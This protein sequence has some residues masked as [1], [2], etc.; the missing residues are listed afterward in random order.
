MEIIQQKLIWF[1]GG[2]AALILLYKLQLGRVGLRKSTLTRLK[3]GVI[4]LMFGSL[5]GVSLRT[6][7]PGSA[8]AS[9]TVAFSIETILGYTVGWG[10]VIWGLVSWGRS[11]FDLRGKPLTTAGSRVISDIITKAMLR[12]DDGKLLFNSFFKELSFILNSQA[13][14][15][16]KI[17]DD[18]RLQ[19]VFHQGLTE[20]SARLLEFPRGDRNVF[21]ITAKSRQAVISDENH[22]LHEFSFPE[23][24]RGQISASISIPVTYNGQLL[25]VM[26][27]YRNKN[28]HFNEDDM[29]VLEIA[30]SGLGA[31]LHK[32]KSDKEHIQEVRYKELLTIA[33]KSLDTGQPMLSALIKSAKTVYNYLPFKWI[34]LYVI[35]NGTPRAYEFNLPTGGTVKIIEGWFPKYAFPHLFNRDPNTGLK[36]SSATGKIP[37]A[38]TYIFPVGNSTSPLGYLEFELQTPLANNSYLPL[39]G[40]MLC[41]RFALYLKNDETQNRINLSSSWLGAVQFF[42]ERAADV[43]DVSS[44][45]K[46]IA[47]SAVDLVPTSFCRIMLADPGKR[48]LKTAALAQKRKLSWK[49]RFESKIS[50]S[51]LEF[52]KTSLESGAVITFDQEDNARRLSEEE[53]FKTLPSEVKCGNIVPLTMGN[54]TVGLITTGD[55]RKA[56]RVFENTDHMHF[57]N[58]L[59]GVVSMILTWH[60]EKRLSQEGTK[61]LTLLQKNMKKGTGSEKAEQRINS[62]INGPLA[63]IMAACEYLKSGLHTEKG[64]LDRYLNIIERNANQIHQ[65]ISSPLP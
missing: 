54:K 7:F 56:G 15:F 30:G 8:F 52:H 65:N 1:M 17:A 49:M 35:G 37:R 57:L 45:L 55:C 63:G 46:E 28:I 4:M 64:D 23:T 19:L 50:L 60:K 10:L 36:I 33:S 29:K 22:T 44:L 31:A 42:L 18:D 12:G 39:L 61:K 48:Y 24:S 41:K 5:W 34:C 13:L 6:L 11:Y 3:I 58:A 9:S 32:E 26:T 53:A 21:A 47:S 20:S 27:A 38:I 43:T 62:R 59:A 25:G 40:S 16:H 14:S 51:N 2:F